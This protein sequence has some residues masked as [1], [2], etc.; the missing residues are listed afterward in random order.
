MTRLELMTSRA[1]K[2]GGTAET[3]LPKLPAGGYLVDAMMRLGPTRSNGMAETPTDWDIILPFAQ[4]TGRLSEA[5]EFEALADM[6][7]A[8]HRGKV[9]GENP[10]CIPPVERG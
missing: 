7:V 2:K 10:L 8:F 3:G 1:E 9:E 4:A 5:W 6:C